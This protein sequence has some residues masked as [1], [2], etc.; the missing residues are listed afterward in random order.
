VTWLW[1][2]QSKVRLL[3]RARDVSLLQNL[4][5]SSRAVSILTRQTTHCPLGARLSM[6]G[7]YPHSLY[8]YMPAW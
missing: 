1:A 8:Y 7:N 2:A 3:A 6:I 5:T 4:K